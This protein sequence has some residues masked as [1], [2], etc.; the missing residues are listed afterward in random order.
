MQ[1]QLSTARSN[2]T[3]FE[4]EVGQAEKAVRE[5]TNNKVK[6]Y[7]EALLAFS[8]HEDG[9]SDAE[10]KSYTNCPRCALLRI[11]ENTYILDSD[12]FTVTVKYHDADT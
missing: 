3:H 8:E 2:V 5:E 6:T 9:C 12:V 10:V 4:Y 1:K 7:V 11:K